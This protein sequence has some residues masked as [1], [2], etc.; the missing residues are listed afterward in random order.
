[1]ISIAI[2]AATSLL[3]FFNAMEIKSQIALD[4]LPCR[5]TEI[6]ET[7]D[8]TLPQYPLEIGE[9][10]GDTIYRMPLKLECRLFVESAD[11]VDF[12]KMLN[13]INFSDDFVSIKSLNGKFYN[14][15][16]IASW[17]RDTSSAMIGAAYYNV[18]LQ[19]FILIQAL[20]A[21]KVKTAANSGK[22][23]LGNKNPQERKSST[24]FKWGEGLG[25]I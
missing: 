8:F 5:I 19:E 10:R 11:F 24:L 7:Q 20:A 13:E 16:K 2:N 14:N 1:M 21:S 4:K 15:L 23:S 18:S 6:N 25:G 17:A 22:K 3:E 9:Y 12:E